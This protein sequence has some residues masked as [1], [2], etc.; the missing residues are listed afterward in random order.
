LRE[1]CGFCIQPQLVPYGPTLPKK[2]KKE[3]PRADEL[4]SG[5][6]VMRSSV[7]DLDTL[8]LVL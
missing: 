6:V 5:L 3:K 7:L 8:S 2:N 1:Y 4:G